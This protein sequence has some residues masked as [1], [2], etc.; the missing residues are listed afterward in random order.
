MKHEII[1]STM[2]K[3]HFRKQYRIKRK[4]SILKNRFFWVGILGLAVLIGV[5]YLICF[6]SFFQLAKIEISGNQKVKTENIKNLTEKEISKKILFFSSKS[7]FLANISEI[8]DKILQEFPHIVNADLQRKFP[9]L[10]KI[11]IEERKPAAVFCQGKNYFFIDK[12]GIIFEEVFGEMF[13]D[14]LKIK[15]QI[16]FTAVGGICS[17]DM[18]GYG[19]ELGKG[20]VDKEKLAQILDIQAKLKKNLKIQINS[21]DIISEQRLDIKTA[22]GWEIYFNTRKDIDWQIIELDLVLKEKIPFEKRGELKYIDLR[23]DKVYYKY[24]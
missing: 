12:D 17:D 13:E 20:V 3:T 4:K 18:C 15:L 7:I 21:A 24:R 19:I 16:P 8:Q 6:C 23:F 11:R 22:E 9:A 10:L 14:M 2:R 1:N 5:F